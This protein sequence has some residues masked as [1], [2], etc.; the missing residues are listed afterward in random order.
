MVLGPPCL[1]V[2]RFLQNQ[3]PSSLPAERR[4]EM[5][6]ERVQTLSAELGHTRE[7]VAASA[8]VDCVLSHCWSFEDD[9]ISTDWHD[10]IELARLLCHMIG[11]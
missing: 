6:W 4:E 10:G 3:L 8:L 11:V 9:G 5:V 7:T 2:G 1:E